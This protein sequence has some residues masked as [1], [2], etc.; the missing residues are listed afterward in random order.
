M[1]ILALRSGWRCL[2]CKHVLDGPSLVELLQ[3]LARETG[4]IFDRPFLHANA[5]LKHT[6]RTQN[7]LDEDFLRIVLHLVRYHGVDWTVI[8]S[9]EQFSIAGATF[10]TTRTIRPSCVLASQNHDFMRELHRMK[11]IREP[12]LPGRALTFCSQCVYIPFRSG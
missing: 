1:R 7:V 11:S 9:L 6:S 4:D 3:Q 8:R 10:Q 12:K 2:L 5:P